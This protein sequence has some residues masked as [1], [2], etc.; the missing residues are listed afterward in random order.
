[1]NSSSNEG[2]GSGSISA[3]LKD[4]PLTH[5]GDLD[6]TGPWALGQ[7]RRHPASVFDQ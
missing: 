1:M 4:A 2:G 5:S 6:V 3:N 7:Q